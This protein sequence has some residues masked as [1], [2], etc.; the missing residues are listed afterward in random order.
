MIRNPADLQHSMEHLVDPLAGWIERIAS[1]NHYDQ[2]TDSSPRNGSRDEFLFWWKQV[3]ELLIEVFHLEL[4][5]LPTADV[6]VGCRPQIPIFVHIQSIDQV[7]E[8]RNWDRSSYQELR[9]H[10]RAIQR[11]ILNE[12]ESAVISVLQLQFDPF[13]FSD[14]N[15][16]TF[17]YIIYRNSS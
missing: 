5:L 15:P 17:Q 6:M 16:F 11:L 13:S 14:S 10:L 3:R 2:M 4:N 9:F 8:Y 12:D 1:Q 7:F